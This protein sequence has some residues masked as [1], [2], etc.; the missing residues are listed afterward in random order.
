MLK[1]YQKIK[2][3]FTSSKYVPLQVV[4]KKDYIH[5]KTTSKKL[6]IATHCGRAGVNWLAEVFDHHTN[7]VGVVEQFPLEESFYRYCNWHGIN[8]NHSRMIILLQNLVIKLWERNDII[9]YGSPWLSANIDFFQ[10]NLKP[11]QTL[12]LFR[13]KLDNVKSFLNKGWYEPREIIDN[14]SFPGLSLNSKFLHHSFSRVFPD[15]N[16]T[17][18]FYNLGKIGKNSWYWETYNE[19]ILNQVIKKNLN[20]QIIKLEDLDQN[21]EHFKKITSDLPIKYIPEKQFISIK[22]KVPNKGFIKIN[23][24]EKD[25]DEFNL[26]YSFSNKFYR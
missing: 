8:A 23:F 26:F 3:K 10:Q 7:C 22:S 1:F 11:D 20:L 16:N 24:S 12:I 25:M 21:Y 13:N 14:G 15:K 18:N 9:F 4:K 6:I 17:P 19:F 2:N 5:F